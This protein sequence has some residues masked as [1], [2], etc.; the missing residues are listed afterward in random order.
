MMA[1]VREYDR[2]VRL[3]AESVMATGKES[4]KQ[5]EMDVRR[6][7]EQVARQ[8]T[9]VPLVVARGL[10][11]TLK[12]RGARATI[13]QWIGNGEVPPYSAQEYEKIRTILDKYQKGARRAL[14]K[15]REEQYND[16]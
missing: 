15:R 7:I 1:K 5:A 2:L 13:N 8:H 14:R 6:E 16:K 4:L 12:R 11:F 10:W 3:I 9:L